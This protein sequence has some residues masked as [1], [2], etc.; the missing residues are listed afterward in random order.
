MA[1]RRTAA[2]AAVGGETAKEAKA[3]TGEVDAQPPGSP[4][5][6]HEPTAEEEIPRGLIETVG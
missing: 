4:A 5:R 3:M 6:G 2:E 1:R